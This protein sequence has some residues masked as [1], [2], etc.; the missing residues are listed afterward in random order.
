MVTK[1][2]HSEHIELAYDDAGAGPCVVLIHGHPFD[3]SVWRPQMEALASAFRVVAPDLRGFGASPVTAHLVTLRQY[4][5]DVERLLDRLGIERA[6]VVGLSMGGL[7]AIDLATTH[8]A[9]FWALGLVATT[10]EPVTAQE[11]AVRRE[12]A[13]RIERDGIQE[14]IEYMH[15][16]LYG[17][18][19]TP[20]VRNLVDTMMAR[21]P[22]VGAAA[23][24]RGHAERPDYRPR[25]RKLAIPAFVCRGSEDP[26]SN[27][28]V[29]NEI[30][31]HLRDPVV[32]VASD[33]GHLPNLEAQDAFTEKLLEFLVR[34]AP[35]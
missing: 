28:T 3:R 27:E 35:R 33:A 14:L 10:V 7:V 24:L 34:H 31:R 20:A 23:A 26:W 19:A 17:T 8:P 22:A 4:A 29:T 11:R 12:R 2:S 5:E 15:S 1:R 13:A 25:L 32:F 21:A 30:I 16:G 9:R 6:A 18:R